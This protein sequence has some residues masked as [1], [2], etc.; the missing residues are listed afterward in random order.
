M[1][2][3]SLDA[4]LRDATDGGTHPVQETAKVEL[5]C[6]PVI[7]TFGDDPCHSRQDV[8]AKEIYKWTHT[9]R[10]PQLNEA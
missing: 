1:H 3:L 10:R 4:E 5:V 8:S 7:Q 6:D 2:A 9:G